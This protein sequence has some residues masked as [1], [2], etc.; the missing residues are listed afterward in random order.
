M[1][2]KSLESQL[3]TTPHT[4]LVTGAAGFI[5]SHLCER[6]LSLDQKVIGLDN[7]HTGLRENIEQLEALSQNKGGKGSFEFV[8]GDIRDA[9]LCTKLVP[10]AQY[11]LHQAALASVPLS[12]KN[13]IEFHE[14]NVNGFLNVLNASRESGVKRFVYASSS[15]IYGDS[16]VLP[17]KE[18]S[19]GKPN[20]PYG[21][22][23]AI[24]D[25]YAATYH[26]VYG[27][28]TVGLRYFNVFGPRQDPSSPYAAVI[29]IWM[30]ALAAGE[31][32]Y[33][34]G[35]GSFSRDFCFI[36]N[37]VQ[38]NLLAAFAPDSALGLSY[39]IGLG[40]KTTL[41]ELYQS[42]KEVLGEM[43]PEL[44]VPDPVFREVRT[45]DTPHSYADISLARSNL[46]YDPK[47]GL[48]EG[49]KKFF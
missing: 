4:W 36:E 47:V 7:F 13:P 20:C 35:D 21:A 38:A 19:V 31:S 23:K 2:Y 17:R 28:P 40:K 1:D 14:V 26:Q 41:I 44:P 39:N 9:E 27:T 6:L 42:L 30:K 16:P 37:V 11:V 15:A 24:N 46:G 48:Y 10:Q 34:N 43:N 18:D 33:I 29:P 45:G 32:V 22:G 49:L 3:M 12:I 25:L 8:E 5:G